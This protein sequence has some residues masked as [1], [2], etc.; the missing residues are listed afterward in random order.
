VPI[1]TFPSTVRG[2]VVCNPSSTLSAPD[3][4]PE[5]ITPVTFTSSLSWSPKDTSPAICSVS[6]ATTSP[7]TSRFPFTV[8]E[9]SIVESPVR[10]KLVAEIVPST[11]N[12]SRVDN[13]APASLRT[14][15][16]TVLTLP[17]LSRVTR[18]KIITLSSV[19]ALPVLTSTSSSSQCS[20]FLPP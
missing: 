18:A 5:R 13:L 12:L 10:F 4:C 2:P 11:S 8:R 16:S 7:F 9:P 14:E 20:F 17:L 15:L 1:P 6:R 3:E 19:G